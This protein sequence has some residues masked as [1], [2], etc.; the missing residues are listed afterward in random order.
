MNFVFKMK[1]VVFKT[2]NCAFK[3]RNIVFEMM[4]FADKG[5]TIDFQEFTTWY[6]ENTDGEKS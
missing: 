5:G 2:K 6:E 3:T 4:Y 1:N